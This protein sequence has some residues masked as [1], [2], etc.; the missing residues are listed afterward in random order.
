[1]YMIL[2]SE[3]YCQLVYTDLYF[4]FLFLFLSSNLCCL[5]QSTFAET[6]TDIFI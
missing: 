2:F 5:F 4:C 6:E 1:M 3:G